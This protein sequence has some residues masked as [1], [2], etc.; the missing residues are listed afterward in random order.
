MN[1]TDIEQEIIKLRAENEAKNDVLSLTGHE[2][3][4]SLTSLKWMLK[5]LL[6]GDFG[7]ITEEQ[8]AAITQGY[9]S[10]DKIITVV[11]DLINF[12]HSSDTTTHFVIINTDII[13]I[14]DEIIKEFASESFKRGIPVFF[15]KTKNALFAD[16]DIDQFKV[17]VSNMMSNALKYSSMGN[18]I[19]INLSTEDG[20]IYIKIRDH[21]IGIPLEEQPDL[22]NKFF[23]ASNAK[24]K[25]NIG[26]GLGLYTSFKIA[27]KLKGDLTF[28]SKEGFGSTFILTIPYSAK[29]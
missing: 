18:G 6:D 27:Q 16:I 23:R 7:A 8:R 12:S 19:E 29:D 1:N 28:E 24:K 10:N 2:L 17:C 22:F 25:E 5:M 3:R 4:T 26:S 15:N 9:E 14:L 21:G 11:N 20:T 13:P